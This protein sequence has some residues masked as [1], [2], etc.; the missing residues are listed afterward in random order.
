FS[1]FAGNTF[2]EVGKVPFTLSVS[3]ND[4]QAGSANGSATVS[5]A[6]S[7]VSLAA[8]LSVQYGL[9]ATLTA[10]VTGYGTPGGNVT[11]YSGS[12]DPANVIGTA[13]LAVGGGK[14]VAS[15][16]TSALTVVESPYPI[17]AKYGGDTDNAQSTASTS[18]A[19]TPAPLQIKA[20]NK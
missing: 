17:I 9:T 15:V 13:A 16:S 10:T 6:P 19:V 5:P 20:E 3:H 7:S 14:D 11:F 4:A 2:N 8:P 12:I 1:V 18:V